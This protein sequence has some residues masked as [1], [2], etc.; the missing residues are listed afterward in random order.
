[1]FLL[2]RI[3]E[4]INVAS[5]FLIHIFMIAAVTVY[6]IF[7]AYAIRAIENSSINEVNRQNG[8]TDGKPS[9]KRVKRSGEEFV[10]T[11]SELAAVSPGL[12]PCVQQALRELLTLGKCSPEELKTLSIGAIDDCYR[13]AEINLNRSQ[14]VVNVGKEIDTRYHSLSRNDEKEE[15]GWTLH[16]SVVFTYTLITTIGY[17]HVAPQTTYGRAFCLVYGLI[18]VPLALLTIADIGL[19]LSKL[20]HKISDLSIA[21]YKKWRKAKNQSARSTGTVVKSS[22]NGSLPNSPHELNEKNEDDEE[23]EFGEVPKRRSSESI[24]LAI[25]FAV[26]LFVGS[27]IISLYEP[28]MDFFTAFY[29]NYISLS[30]IGLG[31]MVPKRE[32][33]YLVITFIYITIGLALTTMLIE[34]AADFLKKLHYFGRKIENVAQTE[35][36]FGGRKMKLQNLIKHLGDQ[37]NVPIEKLE[38]LNLQHFVEE[39]IKVASGEL[40]ALKKFLFVFKQRQC[41]DSQFSNCSIV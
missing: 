38:E 16:N 18:G 3:K 21:A 25:V 30:T 7:G 24:I 8:F 41:K 15:Y 39:S 26:Y 2:N 36:W 19:F 22:S 40:K 27:F 4:G 11:G 20:I 32:N 6:T 34:V 31:D 29:F 10:L 5:P 33:Q 35:I 1:M 17:G 13:F 23:N 12:R 37:L 28:Q 14:K 9:L